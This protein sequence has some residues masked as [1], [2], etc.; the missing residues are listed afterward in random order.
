[1]IQCPTCKTE[2]RPSAKFCTFCGTPLTPEVVEPVPGR[3]M[4]TAGATIVVS[5]TADDASQLVVPLPPAAA[6]DATE[7]SGGQDRLISTTWPDEDEH[8]EAVANR[9][10]VTGD[11]DGPSPIQSP[12]VDSDAATV[13]TWVPAT[14]PPREDVDGAQDTA[15]SDSV[16]AEATVAPAASEWHPVPTESETDGI[17]SGASF[18]AA[19]RDLAHQSAAPSGAPLATDGATAGWPGSVAA[20]GDDG[21]PASASAMAGS[22]A[23]TATPEVFGVGASAPLFAPPAAGEAEDA[24]RRAADLLEELRALLPALGATRL[25]PGALADRLDGALDADSGV[26]EGLRA[27][28]D[29][30][31]ANPRDIDIV[32]DLTRRIDDVIALIDRY[33]RLGA[34]VRHAVRSLRFGDVE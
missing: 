7:R 23:F 24:G 21:L 9:E 31:R 18:R 22:A 29:A 26:P 12:P 8:E 17:G 20:I 32:L 2:V 34:A 33:D 15:D 11:I 30:A 4:P 5:P 28:M 16:A 3:D 27:A 13:T 10:S 1:M 14:T 19:E 6:S 25:Q